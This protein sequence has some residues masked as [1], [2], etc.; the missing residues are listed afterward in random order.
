MFKHWLT[1]SWTPLRADTVRPVRPATTT[2]N[3]GLVR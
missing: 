3:P 1:L 2:D